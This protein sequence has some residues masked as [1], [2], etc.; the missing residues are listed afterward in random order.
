MNKNL[1]RMAK[2][3]SDLGVSYNETNVLH[4]PDELEIN[5]YSAPVRPKIKK[6]R[7]LGMRLSN[8]DDLLSG[9]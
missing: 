4:G 7:R 5:G 8:I 6:C 2:E 9:M 1:V 3:H